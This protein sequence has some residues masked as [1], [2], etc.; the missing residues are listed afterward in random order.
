V[1]RI[2]LSAGRTPKQWRGRVYSA[3]SW[4]E[5]GTILKASAVWE[6]LWSKSVII[7]S[8]W[9]VRTNKKAFGVETWQDSQ[10]L[11]LFIF[12]YEPIR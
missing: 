2:F 3:K 11:F 4:W 5:R 9:G 7:P 1:L 12:N 6:L 8:V 10:G